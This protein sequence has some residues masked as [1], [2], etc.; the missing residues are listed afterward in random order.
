MDGK[1]D[2]SSTS[3]SSSSAADSA[4]SL[5]REF[6]S[7]TSG[8]RRFDSPEDLV[9]FYTAPL[10]RIFGH[11]A[12]PSTLQTPSSSST[13]GGAV[14]VLLIEAVQESLLS[15]IAS[16]WAP[17]LPKEQWQDLVRFSFF[18]PEAS[19]PEKGV[20]QQ[21]ALRTLSRLLSTT[22]KGNLEAVVE[23][24]TA[25]MDH[26]SLPSLIAA[27]RGEKNKARAEVSWNET[28]RL[29]S[30]LPDRVANATEGKVPFSTTRWMEKVWV[31][32][33]VSALNTTDKEKCKLL[34]DV[35]G[36]LD[37]MG[38]LT[39]AVDS[40]GRGF[41]TS[42][43]SAS[44]DFG[45]VGEKWAGLRGRLGRRLRDKLDQTL[46]ET[47]QYR[48]GSTGF[49]TPEEKSRPGAEGQ[50]FLSKGSQ[51]FVAAIVEVF[52]ALL[53]PH[54]SS[55]TE[56][57]SDSDT[58]TDPTVT[59]FNSVALNTRTN[60]S[61]LLAWAWT[62]YLSTHP[63]SLLLT[64]LEL[65]LDQWSDE[66]RLKRNILSEKLYLS[67]LVITL[68]AA[69]PESER[70]GVGDISRSRTFL[71]GV[72]AHLS[73]PEGTTRRVGMLVAELMS[74]RVEGGEGK[75]KR[76]LEFGKGVWNGVGGGREECRV[77]RALF[78]AWAAHDKAIKDV[79]AGWGEDGW[80]EAVKALVK[81]SEGEREGVKEKALTPRKRSSGGQT[82]RF[83]ERVAPPTRGGERKARPLITMLGSDSE[84]E[85]TGEEERGGPL[86]MFNT[87]PPSHARR[88]AP[89]PDSSASSSSSDSDSDAPP[90]GSDDAEIHR[91]AATL[92]GLNPSTTPS[93]PLPSTKPSSKPSRSKNVYDFDE[94]RESHAPSFTKTPPAPVY[95]SQ[96][97][98]LLRSSGRSSIKLALKHA[99]G[100]IRRKSNPAFGGEVRENAIDL[101]LS[102]CALHDNYG[103][104]GFEGFRR[105]ALVALTVGCPVETVGVLGEQVFGSQYSNQQRMGMLAA[106]TE[107]A[108]ELSGRKHEVKKGA[109]GVV[110]RVISEAK[111]V[112]EE[113]VPAMRRERNLQLSHH[114]TGGGKLVQPLDYSSSSTIT[115][116]IAG[117][118]A[119]VGPVYIFPLV[120][121]F[122][123]YHS[124]FSSRPTSTYLGAGTASLFDPETLTLFL[125]TLTVLLSLSPPHL[126][127]TL[128][129]SLLELC[130]LMLP[131][132]PTAS[133]EVAAA[134]NLLAVLLHGNIESDGGE[135]MVRD[136]ELVG[137]L[138]G[139]LPVVQ[140]LFTSLQQDKGGDGGGG[141]RGKI[142][143]RAATIL[144]LM[145]QLDQHRQE[146]LKRLIG[147][148]PA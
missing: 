138:R 96:L 125:D 60:Q 74:G 78:D 70:D 19:S 52:S 38:Y 146:Q 31:T 95:I 47:L 145:D 118:G 87:A 85:P 24:C 71:D 41:W 77:L 17:T 143:S 76:R 135:G 91:L 130:S 27:V 57:S 15:R 132:S 50:A 6:Q 3:S 67:T 48:I 133:I 33:L 4:R 93:F 39:R 66:T 88:S 115:T 110:E 64:C 25:A 92:S 30:S 101:T 16:E 43:L 134:L 79:R 140:E 13:S 22:D 100:L 108:V 32:G 5:R 69:V 136:T 99:A 35:L 123:A 20:V 97:S 46:V 112:G 142:L 28:L 139:L 107:S 86:R 114:N 122:L 105:E 68:L 116:S 62:T 51:T 44:L 12:L 80:R 49:V 147:F 37:R 141:V 120:N 11:S 109:D 65:T 34:R 23:V 59:L 102:L 40:E 98:P 21:C 81:P 83:P 56:S 126:L 14:D 144:L 137:R 148:V 54:A 121:R 7:I 111:R 36:R 45:G 42:L 103:V 58:D 106:V 63:P 2:P 84:P 127:P 128:T 119:L 10:A 26:L 1:M 89:S 73:H 131:T 90:P 61:P 82:R 113:R 94:E 29:L 8:T 9:G 75:G 104:R 129:K 117:W 124:H 55:D 53:R 18:G 72:S